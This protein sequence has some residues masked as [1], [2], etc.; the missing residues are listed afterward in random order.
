MQTTKATVT[1]KTDVA[2]QI[3]GLMRTDPDRNWRGTELPALLDARIIDVFV[4]LPTLHADG[5]I[6][7]VEPGAWRL[8]ATP[9]P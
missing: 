1:A 7:R 6:I 4:A 5:R 2:D 9:K 3:L 8:A